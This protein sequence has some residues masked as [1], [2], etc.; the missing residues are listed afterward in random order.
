MNA[1]ARG[2]RLLTDRFR[3]TGP[4]VD[5]VRPGRALAMTG[6]GLGALAGMY[7]L[8]SSSVLA[9]NFTTTDQTFQLYS[10]Y[11]QGVSAGG[12]VAQNTTATSAGLGGVA[13][14]GIKTAKLD[15]LCAIAHQTLPVVGHVSLVIKA[16]AS[17]AGSFGSSASTN[18][19]DGNGA[20]VPLAADG[21]LTSDAST[22]DATDLFL[23]TNHLSGYGN[24][25]SGLN[26]GQN[27]PDT[28]SSLSSGSWP[29]T[30]TGAP[31]QGGFGLSAQHLNIGYLNGSSYG[32]NLAGAIDLPSLVI[33]V[34]PGD[35]DQTVCPA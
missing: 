24:N 26:L 19:V 31:Q 28:A 11:I 34:V 1:I 3:Y 8:V 29:Q 35:A 30:T 21:T 18:F 16:G 10:N 15:G 13:E 20:P 4:T 23:N 5:G 33:K 2:A 6:V 7:T 32:I 12:Y 22:I 14:L 17:V 25:I 27:A 9:V